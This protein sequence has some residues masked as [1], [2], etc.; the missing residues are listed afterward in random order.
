MPSVRFLGAVALAALVASSVAA[1]SP[2][3]GTAAR[4]VFAAR[5]T[6]CHG[7]DLPHPK[8]RFGYILD[9]R[10][11]A[12]N[13]EMVIPGQPD[14]SELWALVKHGD[15][16]PPDS[17]RG[18]LSATEKEVV[19]AWIAAGAPDASSPPPEPQP[20]VTASAGD[21]AVGWL[22]KF[23]L[24]ALHFPIALIVAAGIAE[25]GSMWRRERMPSA[26]VRFCLW[27]A[28]VSAVPTAALGWMH[29]AAGNGSGSPQLL[30]AHR[31]LGSTTAVSIAFTA[32]VAELDARR[33]VRTLRVRLL[34]AGVVLLTGITAHLGGS[35]AHGPDF[36]T[37]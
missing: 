14:E 21:R 33:G 20:E 34:L 15:M 3:P 9:L 23:H 37:R 13:P 8:G 4:Q 28:A 22:G 19:R 1:Q 31:W 16:P 26:A 5:C 32:V 27:L 10:R 18:P 7:P 25:L 35:L 36:L 2:D 30:L 11:V 6:G 12:D 29:A 24:L 17:P